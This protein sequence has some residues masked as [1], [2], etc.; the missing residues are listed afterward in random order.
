MYSN[1]KMI[2]ILIKKTNFINFIDRDKF[3]FNRLIKGF[4]GFILF[5]L[6]FL[7]T[8]KSFNKSIIL[9]I[10]IL[11]LFIN[12]NLFSANI[13]E[14]NNFN[15][16]SKYQNQENIKENIQDNSQDNSQDNNLN[17]NQN[18]EEE[19]GTGK[20]DI[21]EAD[22][23]ITFEPSRS[24]I[25]TI[26]IKGKYNNGAGVNLSFSTSGFGFGGFYEYKISE[27]VSL[28]MD[29]LMSGARNTDEFERFD[30]TTG[31]LV[32]D[33]KLNRVY[34]FP[35]SIGPSYYVFQN[36][37]FDNFKPFVSGGVGFSTILVA[38]YSKYFVENGQLFQQYV[39]FF[40]AFSEQISYVRPLFYLSIGADFGF[41]KKN[42]S[43]IQIKYY[44]IPFGGDGIYSMVPPSINPFLN[45]KPITN[46][47]GIFITLSIGTKF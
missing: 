31:L 7:F 21:F 37:L 20:K 41:N 44:N 33:N 36:V 14:S 25:D 34:N 17:F 18:E 23:V 2:D 45:S 13:S 39:Q 35:F 22:S 43:R 19:S 30:N 32:V 10:V 1:N 40:D 29:F 11:N 15:Y 4:M 24:L 12:F 27:D 9:I 28:V 3:I 42:I 38:P 5:F 26:N 47:G 16:N 6:D 8:N 46:F